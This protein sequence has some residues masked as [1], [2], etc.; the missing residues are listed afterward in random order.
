MRV[1]PMI[2]A[3]VDIPPLM[4]ASNNVVG[5]MNAMT[6]NP[7]KRPPHAAASLAPIKVM[8]IGFL[9]KMGAFTPPL[10]IPQYNNYYNFKKNP[11]ISSRAFFI[12]Q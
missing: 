10:N 2:A 6:D 4:V 11:R 8:D 5:F 1:D 7:P 12:L 9:K 3:P